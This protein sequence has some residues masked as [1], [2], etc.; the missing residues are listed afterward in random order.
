MTTTPPSIQR[1]PSMNRITVTPS[2]AT[3]WL[4]NQNNLNRPVIR[5]VVKRYARAMKAGQWRLTHQGIAFDPH[6]RL[7]DGQH[8]LWAVVEADVPVEMHVWF[9]VPADEAM[10]I[11]GGKGRSIADQLRLC[12]GAGK[13]T[14]VRMS[15][16]R[17]M[18][19]RGERATVTSDEAFDVL[20]RHALALEFAFENLP[21]RGERGIAAADCRAV[22]VRAWYSN[23]HAQLAR[24][25]EILSTSMARQERDE[26]VIMLR[27]FLMTT[28]QR[29]AS[30]QRERYA[31]IE[32]ALMAFL[33]GEPLTRLHAASGELFLL[34][35]EVAAEK[36]R[37]VA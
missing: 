18:L 36:A 3:R 5:A 9:N 28:D 30:R 1:A 34:P 11:D 14:P 12:G 37:E 2:Q 6:G 20:T 27:T 19:G 26:P 13:A 17:A 15:V 29:S 35:E 8:R 25:C 23:D 22:I 10:V 32:R 24:F 31:K 33:T 21:L 7:L 4:D 16:V